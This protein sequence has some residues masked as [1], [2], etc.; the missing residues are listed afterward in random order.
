M[1]VEGYA[2]RHSRTAQTLRKMK[3][4]LAETH[5]PDRPALA[6]IYYYSA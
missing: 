5:K 6:H 3:G 2:R 1:N 4:R